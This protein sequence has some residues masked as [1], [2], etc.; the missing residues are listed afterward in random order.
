MYGDI[1]GKELET[2]KCELSFPQ[3]SIHDLIWMASDV[4]AIYDSHFPY[5]QGVTGG[6]DQTSGEC[7]LC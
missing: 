6:M 7:S 2:M 4:F 5:I 1:L 3:A